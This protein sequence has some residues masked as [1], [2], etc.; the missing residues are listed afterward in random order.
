MNMLPCKHLIALKSHQS[1]PLLPVTHPT[2]YN[3]PFWPLPS[4]KG[5]CQENSMAVMSVSVK[6]RLIRALTMPRSQRDDYYLLLWEQQVVL[7]RLH[8]RHNRL[9]SHMHGKLKLASLPTCPCGQEDQATEHVLQRCKR[10]CMACQHF[11]DNQTL[12]LQAG[13]GEDVIHLLNGLDHGLWT[14]RRRRRRPLPF[15]P[16]RPKNFS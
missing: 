5:G 7:V 1:N 2:P 13:A 12:Q 4:C 14:P 3:P 8:T 16:I 15:S 11:P 9:N 6:R 10:R